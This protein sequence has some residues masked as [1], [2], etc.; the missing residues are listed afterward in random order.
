SCAGNVARGAGAREGSHGRRARAQSPILPAAHVAALGGVAVVES[1]EMERAVHHEPGQL[2][3]RR[4]AKAPGLPAHAVPR[5]PQ[6]AA[7]GT[8]AARFVTIAV[9]V[10]EAQHVGGSI[11]P[12][13]SVVELAQ[14]CVV[15]QQQSDL[16]RATALAPQS[17]SH[18]RAQ[19]RREA[20]KI[21]WTPYGDRH[22][23]GCAWWD[24]QDTARAPETAPWAPG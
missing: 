24:R 23:P 13:I 6:T 21:T 22:R 19:R 11:E 20:G 5:H 17:G 9:V 14:G 8:H 12:A 2:L 10:S 4:Q 1:G 7:D 3:A 18:Q 16:P 15:G